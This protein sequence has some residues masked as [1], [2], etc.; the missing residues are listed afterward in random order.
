MKSNKIF[1]LFIQFLPVLLTIV[2]FLIFLL[3][4]RNVEIRKEDQSVLTT[5]SFTL[6]G[7]ALTSF[8][9]IINLTSNNQIIKNVISKGHFLP[10]VLSLSFMGFVSVLSLIFYLCKLPSFLILFSFFTNIACLSI[11]VFIIAV[12]GKENL[13]C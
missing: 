3:L 7:F 13:N 12:L 2:I 1:K 11:M 4:F 10:I 6:F 5:I 8:S 9:I